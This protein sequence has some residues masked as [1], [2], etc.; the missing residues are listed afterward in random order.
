LCAPFDSA[1]VDFRDYCSAGREKDLSDYLYSS[2]HMIALTASKNARIVALTT[3]QSSNLHAGM[4][5]G[6]VRS[7]SKELAGKGGVMNMVNVTKGKGEVG[8]AEFLAG[9][10]AAFVNGQ[11]VDVEIPDEESREYYEKRGRGKAVVTGAARGIGLQTVKRLKELG[12]EVYGVDHPAGDFGALEEVG[13][14]GVVK[15]D[16]TDEVAGDLIAGAVGGGVNLMVHAAGITRDKTMKRMK[17]GLWDDVVAVNLLAIQR[18]DSQ[19]IENGG[20][21]DGARVV[22]VSSTSGVAGNVGQGN[23]AASKSGLIGYVEDMNGSH[24]RFTWNNVAPGFINTDMTSNLPLVN[25]VVTTRVLTPLKTMGEPEDVA[26]V[27]GWLGVGGK[28][29]RG[30][31]VRVCGGMLVGR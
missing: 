13:V 8:A 5:E 28:G 1:I 19:M 29:V 11:R 10:G 17:R 24:A 27:I 9:D 15:L 21:N 3:T 26:G 14:E 22:G 18:M 2:S 31:T 16:V 6:L 25:E 20:Y 4:V 23:Y 30:Q 12:F 7:L